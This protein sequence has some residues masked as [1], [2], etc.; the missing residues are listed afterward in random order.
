MDVRDINNYREFK[1]GRVTNPLDP[2]YVLKD[3]TG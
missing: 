2:V 1:S 3:E